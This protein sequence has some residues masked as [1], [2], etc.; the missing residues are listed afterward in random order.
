MALFRPLSSA[1][2]G[3]ALAVVFACSTA[4][5]LAAQSLKE[6]VRIGTERDPTVEALQRAVGRETTNIEIARDGKR[7]QLSISG[8]T[9]T[10]DEDP[11][12]TVTIRQVLLDWGQVKSKIAAASHARV[13]VVAQLKMAVEDLT[14]EISELYL[15]LETLQMKIAKT[16]DYIA[17]A[18]R[19]EGHSRARVS[20]GL[21]DS[22]EIARARLEI[23]RAEERMTQLLADQSIT[24]SQIEF[25][26][27]Q[28]LNSP[29]TPP[30]LA[31]TE[32]FASSSSV[33]SAIVIAPAYV[34]AKADLDITTEG[35]KVARAANKPKIMLQA[36]G[37]Q[38]LTGGRG[39][40]GAIGITA[41]VDLN[42][43]GFS[44]RAVLAAEQDRDAAE[45]RLKAVERDL[46]NSVRVYVEQIGVLRSNE[47]SQRKQLDQARE[48]LDAYEQQFVAGRRELIDLLTTGRDHYETEIDQIETYKERKH[49]EYAA[50]HSVGMLGSL[51]FGSR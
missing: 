14:L 13:K 45:S 5:P 32:R 35:I 2:R 18:E 37:R 29:G 3:A 22:A 24:S 36:Q 8:A 26:I 50:A 42:A 46:Q 44:G 33:I 27:G 10:T 20:A 39:R 49:T 28:S 43:T 47:T 25:L 19:I 1:S 31:F 41:G 9:S 40:S 4:L 48:V 17:F 7:P 12:L 30:N 6:A 34:E 51:L 15:E 23:A 16:S 38:D 21:S 11:A